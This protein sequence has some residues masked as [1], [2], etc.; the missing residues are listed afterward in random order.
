MEQF[1]APFLGKKNCAAPQ[2]AGF[3]NLTCHPPEEYFTSL[4]NFHM[5]FTD[6]PHCMAV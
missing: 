1:F 3:K 6:K 5:A 2:K 4:R